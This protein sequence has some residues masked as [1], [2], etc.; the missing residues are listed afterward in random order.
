MNHGDAWELLPWLVNGRL[1]ETDRLRVE[2]HLKDC[3]ACRDEVAVQQRLR[4]ALAAHG[5]VEQFPAAGLNKLRQRIDQLS[6]PLPQA[7]PGREAT[8]DSAR[9]G[10]A[11]AIAAS[12]LVAALSVGGLAAH[13]RPAPSPVPA[14][15]AYLTVTAA[16]P[17][18]SGTV[19]R[20]VFAP[21]VT[22]ADLQ[23]LLAEAHLGIVA[24]PTEAGVYTLALTGTES[25]AWSLQRLRAHD[26]VRF[27]EAIPAAAGR[28]P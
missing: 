8:P 13:Y 10:R 2:M 20:A 25:P 26:G 19:I 17:Q 27:A 11:A 28:A 15:G 9:P 14:G 23:G 12:V 21:T 7:T 22:V 24:G 4:D 16:A 6:V 1:D 5:P 18:Y 3:V